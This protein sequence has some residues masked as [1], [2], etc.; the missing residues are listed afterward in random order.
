M[1]VDINKFVQ[2]DC[3]GRGCFAHAYKILDKD[4]GKEYV[5]KISINRIDYDHISEKD[6][7]TALERELNINS[8][9]SHPC[10]TKFYGYSLYD[11]DNS[12]RPMIIIEYAPKGTL[13]SIVNLE[14][15]GFVID[16]WDSTQKL[17]IIYGIAA[18]MA[19]LHS[20]NI[21]HRDLKLD[22]I[23]LD[24]N[25]C[26]KIADFGLSKIYTVTS[27]PSPNDRGPSIYFAPETICDNKY[28]QKTD[29]YSFAFILY[30]LL[31]GKVQYPNLSMLEFLENVVYKDLR[32][33]IKKDIPASY[34]KLIEDCW[35][36]LPSD[37]P[38]FNQILE[39]LQRDPGF[40]TSNVNKERFFNYIDLIK[41]SESSFNPK[42]QI[43]YYS[44]DQRKIQIQSEQQISSN[45][46]SQNKN[47]FA[48]SV[49]PA[50]RSASLS[51]TSDI[52]SANNFVSSVYLPS[53]TNHINMSDFQ[54]IPNSFCK[55]YYPSPYVTS[56]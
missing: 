19:Y 6:D 20:N 34:R 44:K 10:I 21:L 31:I 3:I 9:I 41:N 54:Q 27:S 38:S 18:G 22:N 32:P 47:C 45:F 42:S 23:L 55:S 48:T 56:K 16:G 52:L 14:R 4:S 11:F 43:I 7:I 1:Y 24:S 13:Q 8:K 12:P 28:S 35:S 50:P 2:L 53:S 46:N 30:E 51:C 37:R 39:R 36:K 40:I 25:L 33:D 29:V 49:Y 26:A 17:I 5:A 15:N